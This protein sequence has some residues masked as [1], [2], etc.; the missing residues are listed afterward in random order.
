MAKV[1]KIGIVDDHAVL[2]KAI[3]SIIEDS[4]EFIIS[5]EAENGI[6]LIKKVGKIDPKDIPDLL[7]ID[8]NMPMM[9]GFETVSWVKSHLLE[10]KILIMS[11]Y[12]DEEKV[13]RLIKMGVNGY[14][15]KSSGVEEIHVVLKNILKKGFHHSD[16]IAEKLLD[17]IRREINP[18]NEPGEMAV[19]IW[20]SL[21]D[22]ER[23]LAQLSCSEL[24]YAEIADIMKLSNKTIEGYRNNLFV[25]CKIKTRVGL[26]MFL[27]KNK[28]VS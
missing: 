13:L 8:I 25:K 24:K 20:Q 21:T 15:P 17:S 27:I 6:D 23:R 22:N 19:S 9:N 14:L 28:L 18:D 2:R 16:F 5:V 11:A 4:A 26:V 3:I 10:T 1:Y 7:V 12:A